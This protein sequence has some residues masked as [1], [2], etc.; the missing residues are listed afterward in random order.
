M[1]MHP[2]HTFQYPKVTPVAPQAPKPAGQ[3]AKVQ[4]AA[5]TKS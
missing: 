4:A 3:V 5:R 1:Q 2:T